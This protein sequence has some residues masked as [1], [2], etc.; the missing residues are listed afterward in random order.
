MSMT[1]KLIET[2]VAVKVE[3]NNRFILRDERGF[4]TMTTDR[5]DRLPQAPLSYTRDSLRIEG[6]KTV[7]V[8]E[9]VAIE[10]IDDKEYYRGLLR[11]LMMT[12]AVIAVAAGCG[13]ARCFYVLPGIATIEPI[14]VV[15]KRK[16]VTFV[17]DINEHVI[18]MLFKDRT[19]E[20]LYYLP[21]VVWSRLIPLL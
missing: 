3:P 13:M 20:T 12:T 5:L 2:P 10:D 19:E 8:F 14:D 21:D 11:Y 16:N 18:E 9:K 15:R 1:I 17:D 6:L 7:P 4:F